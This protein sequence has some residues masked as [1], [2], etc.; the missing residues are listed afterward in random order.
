MEKLERAF[1]NIVILVCSC[2]MVLGLPSQSAGQVN[3][4]APF[5]VAD[6]YNALS[7][8]Y[9]FQRVNDVIC[10]RDEGSAGG[11]RQGA[12]RVGLDIESVLSFNFGNKTSSNDW[13]N[14]K[15]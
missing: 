5:M 6:E 3:D 14:W 8:N 13:I 1:S 9:Y 10:T 4:C 7:D 11:A 2:F 12:A 15:R